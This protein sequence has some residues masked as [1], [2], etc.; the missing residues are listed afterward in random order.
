MTKKH[1]FFE[2]LSFVTMCIWLALLATSLVF[3]RIDC[4]NL[5]FYAMIGVFSLAKAKDT[6]DQ[7]NDITEGKIESKKQ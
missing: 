3:A 1:P 2:D 5:L 6:F 7:L 4:E